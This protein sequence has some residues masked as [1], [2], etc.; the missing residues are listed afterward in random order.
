MNILTRMSLLAL[1][2]ASHACAHTKESLAEEFFALTYNTKAMHDAMDPLLSQIAQFENIASTDIASFK[3]KTMERYLG[4]LKVNVCKVYTHEFTQS[5]LEALVAFYGSG[6]GEKVRDKQT[7]INNALLPSLGAFATIA[8]QVAAEYRP[9]E[10][11]GLPG[12]KNVERNTILQLDK[13][14][15]SKHGDARELFT[16]AIKANGITVVKFSAT[17]CNPCRQ[18]APIFKSVAQKYPE[19]IHEGH[20]IPVHYVSVDVDAFPALAKHCKVGP[21]P[22][23]ILYKDGIQQEVILG[24]QEEATLIQKIENLAHQ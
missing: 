18:Y 15:D 17:W 9:G 13:Q 20:V 22:T 10:A 4:Q 23:T 24:K 2:I 21:V 8:Q 1:V 7:A 19:V 6:V 11:Q 14:F 5:D 3:R 16:Q 12:T